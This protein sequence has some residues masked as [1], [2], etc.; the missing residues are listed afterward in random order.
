MET[1]IYETK[2]IGALIVTFSVPAILSLVMEI[3]TS[4]VDTVFAGHLGEA[5]TNALAAMGLLSPV[6]S[7]FTAFQALYAVSTAILIARHL[8]GEEERNSYFST[9]ILC[10]VLVSAVVSA[11]SFCGMENMLHLL[12]AEKE[13]FDL[14][15]NYLQ[16]QLISNV[17]SAVGY[18]LT[19]CIRTFGYPKMEMVITT[20]AVGVNMIANAIFAFGF[21][22]GFSGLA[23]GTLASEVFCMLLAVGWII[24]KGLFPSFWHLHC[25]T[26]CCR[27]WELFRLGFVQTV[28]QVLAGCTGFF[29]NNSLMLHASANYVAI[30]NIVQKVYTLLLMPIVGI[31][32]GIQTMIAYY[33]GYKQETKK[34]RTIRLAVF[35]T[36]LYGCISTAGVFLFGNRILGI[37]GSDDIMLT[38]STAVLNIVFLTFPVVGIFYTILTLL[39][40]TAHEIKAVIL[41]L[42]RQ[43]F[44]CCRWFI[45]FRPFFHS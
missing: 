6:L 33:S 26:L 45:C 35:Y 44:F 30:W 16:I 3:M 29:V 9:G 38:Q 19:S 40:V 42:L 34:Q 17:F 41:T 28:I 4:V 12:G 43:V 11:V 37:F 27:A 18:T 1:N 21:Q 39:E 14:A 32:Q 22:M 7:V 24:K 23:L 8:N 31:T 25:A 36:V 2:P 15:E 5:G 20:L 13:I 10:S